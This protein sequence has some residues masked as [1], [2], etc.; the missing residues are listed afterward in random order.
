MKGDQ[1]APWCVI[2]LQPDYLRL[3]HQSSCSL[4]LDNLNTR[5]NSLNAGIGKLENFIIIASHSFQVW[6]VL[7]KP[8]GRWAQASNG[9]PWAGPWAWLMPVRSACHNTKR[10]CGQIPSFHAS[11]HRAWI[12]FFSYIN[13]YI[14]HVYDVFFRKLVPK[15]GLITHLLAWRLFS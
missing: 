13:M 4:L 7:A 2:V 1:G 15:I 9:Q 8:S 12:H 6:K 10:Y 5:S 11:T 3:S 14:V